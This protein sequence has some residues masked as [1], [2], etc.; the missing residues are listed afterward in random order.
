[1]TIV[2]SKEIRGITLKLIVFII[3]QTIVITGAV[4][5]TYYKVRSEIRLNRQTQTDYEK[6][7]D[8]KIQTLQTEQSIERNELSGMNQQL[9]SLQIRYAADHSS[10]LNR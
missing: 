1:M 8:L 4:V 7:N 5:G 3:S 10:P 6:F 9:N 2:E